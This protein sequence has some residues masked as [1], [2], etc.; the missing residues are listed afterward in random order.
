MTADSKKK[1]SS[2]RG[3]VYHIRGCTLKVKFEVDEKGR[4]I[5]LVFML[6]GPEERSKMALSKGKW[7]NPRS[8]DRN[9]IQLCEKGMGKPTPE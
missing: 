1:Y 3:F 8:H 7:A 9:T 2:S 4:W 6:Q 5:G